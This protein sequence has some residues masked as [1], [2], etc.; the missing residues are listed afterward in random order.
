MHRGQ[1]HEAIGQHLQDDRELPRDLSHMDA[2][3]GLV[4][5][6]VEHLHAVA[7]Q[8]RAAFSGEEPP[9]VHLREMRNH[10]S[11]I[12]VLAGDRGANPGE[13]LWVGTILQHE[14]SAHV[15]PPLIV[16]TGYTLYNTW[17]L[18]HTPAQC[19]A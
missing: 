18:R 8:G 7:L 15:V 1:M 17:V 2:E 4:F 10:E 9:R 6:Q 3:V 11:N 19:H 13:Q 14:C 5:A 12:F 16:A